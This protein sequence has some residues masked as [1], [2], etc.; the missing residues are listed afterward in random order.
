M[1]LLRL[2][3]VAA[4]ARGWR[5]GFTIDAPFSSLSLPLAS[6]P[7]GGLL[8]ASRLL[9]RGAGRSLTLRSGRGLLRPARLRASLS[10]EAPRS[11]AAADVLLDSRPWSPRE[12]APALPGPPAARASG[13]PVRRARFPQ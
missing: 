2:S 13:R 3:S 6:L 11:P 4:A 10:C 12:Q 8:L 9:S 5:T 1:A 7:R